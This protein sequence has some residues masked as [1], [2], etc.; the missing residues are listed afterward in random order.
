MDTGGGLLGLNDEAVV[1]EKTDVM[2]VPAVVGFGIANQNVAGD[3]WVS[4]RNVYRP[5]PGVVFDAAV[6]A[7]LLIG[8]NGGFGEHVV[9]ET[10]AIE[11]AATVTVFAPDDFASGSDVVAADYAGSLRKSGGV[12]LRKQRVGVFFRAPVE[13][14]CQM[15]IVGANRGVSQLLK[16]P[17]A[18]VVARHVTLSRANR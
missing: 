14:V 7:F 16:T 9:D 4:E 10:D 13:K 8:D 18:D 5:R 17:G 15:G 2:V 6:P 3:S 12:P 11:V 1:V